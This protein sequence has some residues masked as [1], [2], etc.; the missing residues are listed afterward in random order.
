MAV[1]ARDVMETQVVT[2]DANASLLDAYRLFVEEDISGAPVVDEDGRVMGVLS[3]R[4]LLR[5]TEEERDTALVQTTYFRDLAEFSGPDWGTTT[6]DF[7]D[8]MS[9]RTVADVMTPGAIVVSPDATIPEVASTLRRRH[10]H[11]V[12]VAEDER[13]L[14]LI[15]T[16]D[17]VALLEKESPPR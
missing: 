4:D 1:L 6:E 7:Q 2:I 10:V 12:L 9:E 8:R 3:V 13:L 5:A 11:R 15:S 16:F 14:G 17:L